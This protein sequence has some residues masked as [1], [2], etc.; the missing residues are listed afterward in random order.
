MMGE[1]TVA[2]E[3]LFYEFSQERHV[4]SDHLLRS[5]DRFVDLSGIREQLRPY[6]SEMGSAFDRSGADDPHAD[7]GILH[8]HPLG[9]AM[10]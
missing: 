5:V 8:G 2:Q 4:P 6:Y 3:P 9:A 7:R 10:R 1:R